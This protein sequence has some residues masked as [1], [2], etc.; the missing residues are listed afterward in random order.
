MLT[1]AP[2]TA[3][4]VLD[5]ITANLSTKMTYIV[6]DGSCARLA[7]VRGVEMGSSV[8][9]HSKVLCLCTSF[10]FSF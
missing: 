10:A 6:L 1:S 5:S 2:T 9:K 3:V 8:S 7:V 4:H